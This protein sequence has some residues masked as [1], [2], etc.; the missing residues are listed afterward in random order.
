M[1]ALPYI[2]GVVDGRLLLALCRTSTAR[3]LDL[4]QKGMSTVR[5]PKIEGIDER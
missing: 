3:L 1:T 4:E 5:S 2:L